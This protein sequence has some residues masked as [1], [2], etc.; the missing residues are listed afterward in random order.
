MGTVILVIHVIACIFLIVFVLLQ[1]GKGADAGA[2]FGGGI[3]QTYFGSQGGNLLTKI[4]SLLAIV[5]MLTSI[6][7]TVLYHQ[8]AKQSVVSD[9]TVDAEDTI[10]QVEQKDDKK[11]KENSSND[12]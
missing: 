1:A 2:T 12:K 5:F 7:L 4:T 3:G 8:K 9:L 10:K 6:S 11:T